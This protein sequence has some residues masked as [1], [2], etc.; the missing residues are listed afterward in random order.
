MYNA[1]LKTVVPVLVLSIL[2]MLTSAVG[3]CVE[4][5]S[6]LV[7]WWTAD[8]NAFDIIGGEHGTLVGG[9]T[10]G[11]GEVGE[12]FALDGVDG[13]VVVPDDPTAAFNFTGA[14][15]IDAWV[16]IDQYST[17]FGPI[18]SKWND[19]G[20]DS[21][22]YF[23]TIEST[24]FGANRLRFDVSRNGQF[25]G[26]NSAIRY[27]TGAVPTGEWVFVAGVFDPTQANVADRMKVYVNGVDVSGAAFVPTEVTSVF[28]NTEPLRIGA[29]DLGSNAR[30]FFNGSIDEVELFDRALSATE[31]SGLFGAGDSGK[32]VPISIDIKPGSDINPINLGSKGTT[33]VALLGTEVFDVTTVD[34]TSIRFAGAPIR[35][36]PNGRLHYSY[37]DV[38]SDGI[39]DLM[40]HFS[41]V[42]LDLDRDSTEATLTGIGGDDRCISGTDVV[43]PVPPLSQVPVRT[44]P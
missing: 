6:D 21:R 3:Q 23:L 8:G 5:P 36:K 15:T 35:T 26:T 13:Q 1:K 28:V 43:R 25:L 31:I 18:V 24:E 40:M 16:F 14:F 27:S 12:A 17:E 9:A 7:H 37:E 33:P 29:G 10:F 22:A 32:T 41:T 30:D 44:K 38:N 4:A 19:I 2:G 11:S 34:V 42:D 20:T 39:L